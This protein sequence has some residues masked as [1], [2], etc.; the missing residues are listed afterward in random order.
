MICRL[1]CADLYENAAY[2]RETCKPKK[3][4]LDSNIIED[5]ATKNSYDLAC[6][7]SSSATFFD[8]RLLE[9]GVLMY[10]FTFV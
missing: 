3:K 2:G 8:Q 1:V 5:K 6:D 9:S 10:V 7:S 4:P